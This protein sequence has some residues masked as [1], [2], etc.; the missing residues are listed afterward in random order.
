MPWRILNANDILLCGE[1]LEIKLERQSSVLGD[2]EMRISKTK[3]EY[4]CT[5]T[6]GVDR[7]IRLDREEIKKVDKYKYLGSVVSA[8]GNMEEKVKH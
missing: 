1:T 3:T 2:R 7:V 6:I 5:T 8:N 4:M